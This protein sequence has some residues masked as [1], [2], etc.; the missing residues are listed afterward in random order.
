MTEENAIGDFITDARPQVDVKAA[1]KYFDGLFFSGT[2]EQ[3]SLDHQILVTLARRRIKNEGTLAGYIHRRLRDE[4]FQDS[5][6]RLESRGFITRKLREWGL[7]GLGRTFRTTAA[8]RSLR[9]RV[10]TSHTRDWTSFF[11]RS[12]RATGFPALHTSIAEV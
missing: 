3:V 1:R 10:I 8:K 12:G 4:A 11:R 6:A 2:A 5:L 7:E 9:T